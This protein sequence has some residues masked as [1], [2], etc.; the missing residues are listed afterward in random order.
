MSVLKNGR[1]IQDYISTQPLNIEFKKGD[2]VKIERRKT[3]WSGWIWCTSDD[4]I[5]C[6]APESYLDISGDKA[7]FKT[8]YS[9]LELTAR[10]GERLKIIKETAEWYYCHNENDI[11]GWVPVENVEIE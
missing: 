3:E 6:W 11:I 5:E 8:D 7:Q 2:E 10:K 1:V 9:A 4:N